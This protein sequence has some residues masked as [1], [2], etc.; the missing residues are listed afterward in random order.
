MLA[1][2]VLTTIFMASVLLLASGLWARPWPWAY[3]ARHDYLPDDDDD[4][5]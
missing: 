3:L 1:T 5:S 2:I 4:V